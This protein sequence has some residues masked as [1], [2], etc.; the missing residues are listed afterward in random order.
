M[1]MEFTH[2][3]DSLG[4][5]VLHS[6]WQG[7][8]A[9][10]AVVIWRLALR[11]KSPALRHAGQLAALVGCLGAFLW[12]FAAYLGQT[13]AAFERGATLLN[14]AGHT[15]GSTGLAGF[16]PPFDPGV[17]VGK[18]DFNI[19]R[20]T[21]VLACLWALGFALMSLRYAFA[22]GQVQ[23]LRVMGVSTPNQEWHGRFYQLLRQ[24]GVS[25]RVE[26]LISSNING[27]ITFGML[28]PVVLVPVG[29]LSGLPVDQVEAIL[30]H[31]LAHIRRYDYALNLIQTAVKTVLFYHPAIHI[32]ARWTDR[33]REQACD[34]LAVRQGRDPL[35]LVRG[36]AALRLQTQPTL[37]LAA[38]GTGEDTPLMARLT[39]LTGH[40]PHRGRP[41][42]VMMSVLSALLIGSV[43]LGSTANAHPVPPV[44]PALPDTV[45]AAAPVPPTPPVPPVLPP[46]NLNQ[47]T[48]EI[49]LQ[50]IMKA[51]KSRYKDFEKSMARYE[52]NLD[53]YLENN[54]FSDE[55]IKA[56]EEQFEDL[57]DNM[58]DIFKERREEIKDRHESYMGAKI[59][60]LKAAD[61][62]L[63]AAQQNLIR[64]GNEAVYDAQI[65]AMSDARKDI[66]YQ[67]AQ[68]EAQTAQAQKQ[69]MKAKAHAQ[70][71]QT[72]RIRHE[73]FRDT[74]MTELLKDGLIKTTDETVFL[75]HPNSVNAM[76]LNGKT[77]PPNYRG[78]YCKLLDAHGFSDT[79]S[80]ITIKPDSLTILTDWKNGQHTTRVTYGT[81]IN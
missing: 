76:S 49:S 3:L 27:P 75:S 13:P 52:K 39:R 65:K 9:L 80:Q 28:K 41:E 6:I 68:A 79:K 38:T 81:H 22:F 48:T 21:P 72:T 29:F 1:G 47:I 43:Y 32:I 58:N 50:N 69:A 7:G 78:K 57:A 34:D 11:G 45:I 2:V 19:S 56:F 42:H 67:F 10:L 46:L 73:N 33:D 77:L 31:E 44:A 16:I 14:A 54:S 74:V 60:G 70:Y 4:W 12:T 63:A 40:S 5:A 24:S 64:D 55:D 37:G 25:D 61:E 53:V 20:I 15:G 71:D 35:A 18:T 66:Q 23:Q 36:L 8:F 51:D 30:L 26:L 62:G 17:L 59:Q